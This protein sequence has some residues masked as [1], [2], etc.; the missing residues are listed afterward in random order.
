MAS[1]LKRLL[2]LAGF[3][4]ALYITKDVSDIK[5]KNSGK[6][7]ESEVAGSELVQSYTDE[8]GNCIFTDKG[9]RYSIKDN[10]YVDEKKCEPRTVEAELTPETSPFYEKTGCVPTMVL[11][12]N[13]SEFSELCEDGT[14]LAVLMLLNE[15]CNLKKL[16]EFYG[17]PFEYGCRLYRKSKTLALMKGCCEGLVAKGDEGELRQAYLCSINLN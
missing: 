10:E 1:Y 4:S 8:E 5:T 7:L 16:K 12:R 11:S 9:I 6:N 13:E 17:E 2:L 3:L 15:G 14:D